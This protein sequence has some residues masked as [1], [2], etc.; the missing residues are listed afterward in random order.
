M[1]FIKVMG[2]G[3]TK[4]WLVV[5]RTDDGEEVEV[6]VKLRGSWSAVSE[7]LGVGDGRCSARAGPRYSDR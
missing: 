6:I 4:P 2:S 3:R 5:A 7:W 1:Q